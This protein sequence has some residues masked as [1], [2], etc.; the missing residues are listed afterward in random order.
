MT[1]ADFVRLY[2]VNGESDVPKS[3]KS[4]VTFWNSAHAHGYLCPL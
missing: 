2:F 1:Q 4:K 3:K